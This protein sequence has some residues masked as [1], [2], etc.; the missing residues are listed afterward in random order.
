[1]C[2]AVR[3]R[4]ALDPRSLTALR[5]GLGALTLAD[6]AA[7]AADLDRFYTDTGVLPRAALLDPEATLPPLSLHLAFGAST[8]VLTLFVLAGLFAAAL[9]AGVWPRL[10]AF[11]SWLLAISLQHRNPALL[12]GGDQLLALLLLWC[13]FA[14]LDGRGARAVSLRGTAAL[15]LV[16][17][18]T[19]ALVAQVTLVHLC[20]G[21]L[22]LRESPAWRDGTA[23]GL[24]LQDVS[25]SR[26][27]EA[28]RAHPTLLAG[29][30]WSV[31]A[32]EIA[33][34]LV[35]LLAPLRAGALRAFGVFAL[36]ALHAGIALCLEVGIFPAVSAVGLLALLPS[37][38][39]D[40]LRVPAVPR[41]RAAAPARWREALCILLATCSFATSLGSTWP[42][43]QLP[44]R[45]V[46]A[47]GW[48]G[49]DQGWSMYID[50]REP[51]GWFTVR[52]V[53]TDGAD[54]LLLTE[55][56]PRADA[57]R[58]LNLR[59]HGYMGALARSASMRHLL[60]SSLCREQLL[61]RIEITFSCLHF[62]GDDADVP[63]PPPLEIILCAAEPAGSPDL[64]LP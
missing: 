16:S 12:S 55:G 41:V 59:W 48:L 25:V 40:R 58:Y 27:G 60:A 64:S 10:A 15:P 50:L 32:L 62:C 31:L 49:L 14:P 20:A 45:V 5:V 38:F 18:G 7:R 24:A 51:S 8:G 1:M 29:L 2:A 53:R 37:C 26:W 56:A 30:T 42:P 23:L 47:L 44:P 13:A 34:P 9:V 52:G 35:L 28:L 39:W 4:F 54:I 46:A 22:K 19:A 36:L 21:L 17:V 11:L 43:A 57:R 3:G 61:Q 6:L 63:P 33:G